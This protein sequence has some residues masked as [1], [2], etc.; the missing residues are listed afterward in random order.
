[1][2]RVG[3]LSEEEDNEVAVGQG[4]VKASWQLEAKAFDG[5]TYY[6]DSNLQ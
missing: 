3:A 6:K 5:E 4:Q 2:H 1:M